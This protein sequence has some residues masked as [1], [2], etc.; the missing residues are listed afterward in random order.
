MKLHLQCERLRFLFTKWYDLYMLLSI[1]HF[2]FQAY[3]PPKI[4]SWRYKMLSLFFRR[5]ILYRYGAKLKSQKKK[6]F[7]VDLNSTTETREIVSV[8]K[9]RQAWNSHNDSVRSSPNSYEVRNYY[10][11]QTFKTIFWGAIS[12]YLFIVEIQLKLHKFT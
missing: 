9:Q 1:T 10:T 6:R 12:I 7:N 11:L 5:N 3:F 8:E 2:H 4:M